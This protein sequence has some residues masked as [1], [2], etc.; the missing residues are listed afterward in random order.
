MA[1]EICRYADVSVS[2]AF[3]YVSLCCTYSR[4][5]IPNPSLARASEDMISRSARGTNLSEKRPLATACERIGSVQVTH[6]PMTS[7]ARKVIFGIVTKMQRL[8]QIHMI[9]MTG[10]R[11]TAISLQLAA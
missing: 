4:N 3:D 2:P 6:E 5:G 7:A 1:N 9:V 11:Q 8:V 10:S